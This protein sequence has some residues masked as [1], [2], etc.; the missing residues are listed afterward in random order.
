MVDSLYDL[1]VWQSFH[2]SRELKACNCPVSPVTILNLL[3][4]WNWPWGCAESLKANEK[5][6]GR[7][8]HAG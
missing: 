3:Q 1:Q 2:S 4:D 8:R 7:P 6:N 5:T